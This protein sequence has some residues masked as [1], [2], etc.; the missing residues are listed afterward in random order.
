[1]ALQNA[2]DD[3][4]PEHLGWYVGRTDSLRDL[5]RPHRRAHQTMN[6]RVVVDE[7]KRLAY[8][9]TVV[10]CHAADLPRF[11]DCV[12]DVARGYETERRLEPAHVGTVSSQGTR[13]HAVSNETRVHPAWKW[14]TIGLSGLAV[15]QFWWWNKKAPQVLNLGSGQ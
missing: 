8:P 1:M 10:P 3:D 9:V 15:A 5:I 11:H 2:H 6:D 13:R 14:A 4:G 7:K 12:V